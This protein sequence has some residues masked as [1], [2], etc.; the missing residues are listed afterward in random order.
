MELDEIAIDCISV[1]NDAAATPDSSSTITI[2]SIPKI[3]DAD[4]EAETSSNKGDTEQV[5]AAMSHL[6]ERIADADDE[7]DDSTDYVEL[8]LDV[9]DSVTVVKETFFYRYKSD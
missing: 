1:C 4:A 7:D 3:R 5:A 6:N 8:R 9:R 2:D